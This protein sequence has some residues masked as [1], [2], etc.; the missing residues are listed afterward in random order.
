MCAADCLASAAGPQAASQLVVEPSSRSFLHVDGY[1]NIRS[2][3]LLTHV[4]SCTANYHQATSLHLSINYHQAVY[5]SQRPQQ[6]GQCHVLPDTVTAVIYAKM[7]TMCWKRA[8]V[9]TAGHA[10]PA[11]EIACWCCAAEL[12]RSDSL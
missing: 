12:Y 6:Q 2:K 4:L 7:L 3:A 9:P 8:R 11:L 5:C 10:D 1:V